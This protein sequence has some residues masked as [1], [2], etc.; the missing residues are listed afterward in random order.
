MESRAGAIKRR[1]DELELSLKK[2][3]QSHASLQQLLRALQEADDEDAS[4][5]FQ[6]IRQGADLDSLVRCLRDSRLLMQVHLAP[7][8]RLRYE[9]PVHPQM[10]APLL[11]Q[12]NPYVRSLLYAATRTPYMDN[13]PGSDLMRFD[14]PYIT[15]Y[16]TAIIVDPRLD[17]VKPSQWTNV[18]NDDD[19][20]RS[21]LK[22]YFLYEHLFLN[23][24]HKDLFL[25]DMLSGETE[26]CSSLL[27]NAVLALACVSCHS[28]CSLV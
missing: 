4:K 27:V 3:Q 23:C 13:G 21:L 24:F 10:P 16:A 25:D 26:F 17:A 8:T 11:V 7:E 18:S 22:L 2:L 6:Q 1:H 12:S 20:L 14:S 5:I 15:P 9:F 28:C 19:F